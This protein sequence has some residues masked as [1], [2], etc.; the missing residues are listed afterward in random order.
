VRRHASKLVAAGIVATRK[1]AA[2]AKGGKPK[3]VYDVAGGASERA[4]GDGV[5]GLRPTGLAERR[6]AKGVTA[7]G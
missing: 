2:G 6:T 1:A 4:A 7:C 3:D 5:V